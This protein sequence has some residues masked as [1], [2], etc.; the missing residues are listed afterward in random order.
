MKVPQAHPRT[1]PPAGPADPGGA[2][3][4][5]SGRGTAAQHPATRSATRTSVT[6]LGLLAALNGADHG[7]GA[8]SQ[9]PGRPPGLVYESWAHVEAFDPLDGEP[10]LTLIPDLLV[11]GL[12][13]LTV[14][15]ALGAWVTR[16]PGHQHNGPVVLGLT[17]VLLLVGGGFGP[18]L[19]GLVVGL[20]AMR[21]DA[22]PSPAAGPVE[23]L[24]ARLWPWPLAVASSCFLGLVPGT[25][26][27]YLAGVDS[28]AVVMTL[29]GGAFVATG[30]AV[31]SARAKDRV[32]VA[33]SPAPRPH[34]TSPERR[35]S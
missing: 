23:R 13:T 10:A 12:V 35:H 26:L 28:D 14:A 27:L 25:V 19:L 21:I 11:S 32:V 29:T 15:L 8:I 16:W 4:I 1:S 31:W 30:L 22:S 20:L 17:A 6:V 5:P 34:H 7:I 9:G 18:A 2:R 33:I 24:V 3:A